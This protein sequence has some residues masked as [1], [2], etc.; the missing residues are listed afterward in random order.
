MGEHMTP[1]RHGARLTER[2]QL[3]AAVEAFRVRDQTNRVLRQLRERILEGAYRPSESLPEQALAGELGASRNTVRKALLRLE[4]ENLITI[5]DNKSAKVRAFSLDEVLQ[6]LEVREVLEG[7]A[8]RQSAPRLVENDLAEMRR[9]L[10]E[11]RGCLESNRFLEY[12]QN[13]W[14]FHEIIYRVC[15]NR[16]VVEMIM[17]IKQQLKRYNL[18]TVL[19]PGRGAGSFSE[20]EGILAALE[21]RDAD[22]AEAE[23][24]RHIAS[25]RG[26]LREHH[27]LLF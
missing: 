2:R 23:V 11:M 24:R 15:P 4:S 14:R 25:M 27:A 8:V 7:L 9:I 12:S 16:P 10:G 20:H 19:V 1:A 5:E 18:K 17:T 26:L 21:R 13:N 22:A 3:H 6:Y